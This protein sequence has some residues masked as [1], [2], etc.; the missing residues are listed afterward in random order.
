METATRLLPDCLSGIDK[1]KLFHS[2][3]QLILDTCSQR[4]S[5]RQ[6]PE[7]GI[8][9]DMEPKSYH[10]HP[11]MDMLSQHNETT[12]LIT[13]E[14][15]QSKTGKLQWAV[16]K[17]PYFELLVFG[18]GAIVLHIF[19]AILKHYMNRFEKKDVPLPVHWATHILIILFIVFQVSILHRYMLAQFHQ[20]RS[21]FA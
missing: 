8:D 9:D 13:R 18:V 21:L 4:N 2:I 3:L 7:H 12:R 14:R 6:H 5:E 10:R 20:S 1:I 16:Q 17:A 19:Y 11:S 15:L